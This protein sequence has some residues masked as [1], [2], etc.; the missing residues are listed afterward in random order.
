MSSPYIPTRRVLY[1]VHPSEC[2]A[3]L[4]TAC[5]SG[6]LGSCLCDDFVLLLTLEVPPPFLRWNPCFL[7]LKSSY[8]APLVC[9]TTSWNSFLRKYVGGVNFWKRACPGMCVFYSDVWLIVWPCMEFWVGNYFPPDCRRHCSRLLASR[10]IASELVVRAEEKSEQV[11]CHSGSWSRAEGL[12][13]AGGIFYT[14]YSEIL[15]WCALVWVHA[16]PLHWPGCT[17]IIQHLRVFEVWAIFLN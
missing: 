12:L 13:E 17:L 7:Q 14:W 16:L 1:Q 8:C 4:C 5:T 9:Q 10:A 2:G 6:V 11:W 3:P 15:G